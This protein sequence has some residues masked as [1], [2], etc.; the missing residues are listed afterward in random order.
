ME[1]EKFG[2]VLR[3]ARE[4]GGLKAGWALIT[5]WFVTGSFMNRKIRIQCFSDYCVGHFEPDKLS[6][7]YHFFVVRY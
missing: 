6:G 1:V 2:R 5:W 3:M 4:R 7:L